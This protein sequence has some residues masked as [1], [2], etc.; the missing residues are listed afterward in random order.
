MEPEREG[1]IE[2]IVELLSEEMAEVVRAIREHLK[3]PWLLNPEKGIASE[4]DDTLRLGVENVRAIPGMTSKAPRTAK[5]R[6]R[7][8]RNRP[9]LR[10]APRA[11]MSKN[12]RPM[13]ATLVDKPFD[14]AGWIFEINWDGYRAIA[15]LDKGCVRLYCNGAAFSERYDAVAGAMAK[16]PHRA[17]LD[18]EIVVL[19][20]KGLPSF[21]SL[22]NYRSHCATGH[23][24]YEI[25]D[26]LHLDGHDLCGLPLIQ[27]KQILREILPKV[28]GLA[29]CDHV[30][31]RGL[32][33]FEAV[34]NAGITGM[35]AKDGASKYI[36]G[37]RSECWL[38]VKTESH[39]RQRQRKPWWKF[40]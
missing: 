8:G 29:F 20:D 16:I 25:F 12:I 40:W 6:P 36:P 14:R 1:P 21:E 15:E 39:P 11:P 18:G 26:I 10:D 9:D 5:E 27:R 35:I 7:P 3:E 4:N 34:A 30:K 23:L 33:F 17:V 37:R 19:D 22:K 32:A 2:A 31:E 38:K 13:L 28:P 24:I